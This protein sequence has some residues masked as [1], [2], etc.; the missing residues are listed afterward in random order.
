MQAI[1]STPF[2]LSASASFTYPGRCFFEQVGVKAPGTPK[3]T[4]FFPPKSSALETGFGPPS[5]I[6]VNVASGNLS[7]GWIGMDSSWMLRA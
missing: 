2:A 1:K 7:P 4:T 6:C 5:V 3:S